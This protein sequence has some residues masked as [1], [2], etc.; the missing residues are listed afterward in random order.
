MGIKRNV[1][2]GLASQFFF[3]VSRIVVVPVY[4][5]FM[6][7]EAY[8]LVG[9]FV[10]FTGLLQLLNLGIGSTMLRELS[11]MRGGAVSSATIRYHLRRSEW[12][13]SSISCGFV[14]LIILLAPWISSH[15]LHVRTIAATQV[16]TSLRLMGAAAGIAFLSNLFK[17]GLLG[18]ERQVLLNLLNTV[19]AA[20]RS[21]GVI[22]VLLLVSPSPVA[23]CGYQL[24]VSLFELSVF[25]WFIY[26]SLPRK[27]GE[28]DMTTARSR[29][30][31]RFAGGIAF[32]DLVWAGVLQLD[33]IVLSTA[34]PLASFGYFT[35]ISTAAYGVLLLFAPVL[36]V[37]QPRF[38]VLAAEGHRAEMNKLYFIVSY[39]ISATAF[40]VAGILIVFPA[41]IVFAWT[42]SHTAAN[43]AVS[44]LPLYAFG[45]ALV[46]V[47]SLPFLLQFA[48]GDIRIHIIGHL[49]T[50]VGYIPCAV[51]LGFHYGAWGTGI[52]WL[53]LNGTYL[54][55]VV[56]FID[57]RVLPGEHI[58]WFFRTVLPGG[59]LPLIVLLAASRLPLPCS[60]GLLVMTLCLMC[61][62]ALTIS[63][64]GSS[65]YR[66][67]MR[68][69]LNDLS[70]SITRIRT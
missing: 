64:G 62:C 17:G 51:W 38:S 60:R 13:L 16:T 40:S 63:L 21:F 47:L 4:L 7:I 29:E 57:A 27:A 5:R 41:Q 24:G 66:S 1:A 25:W 45:N 68:A 32:T 19:V 36:Q 14:V 65:H 6:G 48:L 3:V 15:W 61:A 30:F 18:L 20:L 44:I 50:A 2:V 23:F 10:V 31:K 12:I 35:I 70:A 43:A 39:G 8:G 54:L 28:I 11:R 69:Y 52:A 33:R 46:S 56:P 34:L 9:L 53:I 67:V 42:G 59:A 58:R 22:V 49:A 55:V 37:L 26:R